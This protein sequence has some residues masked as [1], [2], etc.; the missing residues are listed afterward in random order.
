MSRLIRFFTRGIGEVCDPRLIPHAI[1]LLTLLSSQANMLPAQSEKDLATLEEAAA[2]CRAGSVKKA[3]KKFNKLIKRFP[4]WAEPLWELGLCH[5]SLA[6]FQQAG[7]AFEKVLSVD[8]GHKAAESN[9]DLVSYFDRISFREILSSLMNREHD[10]AV[11]LIEAAIQK[12]ENPDR[13]LIQGALVASSSAQG[14]QEDF[15][16]RPI[17][18]LFVKRKLWG[19][20]FTLIDLW[21]TNLPDTA[22]EISL[23]GIISFL[24]TR[25]YD[26]AVDLIEVFVQK[27]EDP[28]DILRALASSFTQARGFYFLGLVTD[29]LIRRQSWDLALS[30][31][32]LWEKDRPTAAPTIQ[33]KR[34]HIYLLTRQLEEARRIHDGLIAACSTGEVCPVRPQEFFERF[35]TQFKMPQAIRTS[36]AVYTDEAIGAKVWGH[37]ICTG[38]VE[39]DGTISQLEVTKGLGYGLDESALRDLQQWRFVPGTLNGKPIRVRATIEIT[40]NLR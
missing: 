12:G 28:H 32:E 4:T 19:A 34:G 25:E 30:L 21:E 8:P 5:Q 7:E 40:F 29:R 18:R 6:Q 23:R 27:G 16:Y 3:Q 26:D 31:L 10:H 24:T 36:T 14:N 2:L 9:L 1:F 22:P 17:T 13:L 11:D 15:F 33:A 20:A 38:V 37:V 35:G 39:L